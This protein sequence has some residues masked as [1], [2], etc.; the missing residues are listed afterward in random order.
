MGKLIAYCKICEAEIIRIPGIF[1]EYPPTQE[2]ARTK[3]I[4]EAAAQHLL[5]EHTKEERAAA[6]KGDVFWRTTLEEGGG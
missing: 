1:V 3:L 2:K 6:L 4:I 5:E